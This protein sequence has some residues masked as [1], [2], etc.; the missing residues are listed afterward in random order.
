MRD[1]VAPPDPDPVIAAYRKV[2]DASLLR[3]NL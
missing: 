2:V 1:D 3:K